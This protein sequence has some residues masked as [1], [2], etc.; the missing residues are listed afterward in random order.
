MLKDALCKLLEVGI[1][2]ILNVILVSMYSLYLHI[3]FVLGKLVYVKPA[4]FADDI[5][6]AWKGLFLV[7]Q[8]Y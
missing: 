7:R 4:A 2:A 5:E 3:R 8:I 1:I 6:N